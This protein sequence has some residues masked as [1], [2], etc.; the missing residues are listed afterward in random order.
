M[1]D[2]FHAYIQHSPFYL[3]EE[4]K[5]LLTV[6]IFNDTV[7]LT[8]VNVMDYSLLLGIDEENNRI[9]ST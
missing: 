8:K 1:D 6:S 5:R 2:N 3:S 9:M 4:A 7:F